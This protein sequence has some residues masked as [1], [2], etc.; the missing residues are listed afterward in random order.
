MTPATLKIKKK[1]LEKG[2]SFQGLA[3]RWG[4]T[5]ELLTKVASCQRGTGP[6]ARRAQKK[7]ARYVGATVAEVFGETANDKAAAA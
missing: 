7:L 3:D 1:M 5:R 6:D 4:F 2:D